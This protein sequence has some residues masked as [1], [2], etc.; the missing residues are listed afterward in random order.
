MKV[1]ENALYILTAL[2]YRKVGNAAITQ[3]V[4]NPG[5]VDELLAL[6]KTC[7]NPITRKDFERQRASIEEALEELT[8]YADGVVAFGDEEFPQYRGSVPPRAR[9]VALC[10]RGDLGLL[11]SANRN[12]A[13]IGL[14]NPDEY[15]MRFEREVV[16]ALVAEGATIVSGLAAGCDTVAHDETL[17]CGGKTV[18]I[19][20]SPLNNVLP[21]GNWELAEEI[22]DKGGL[23]ISE[24]YRQHQSWPELRRR[25][26]E[27]DRLQALFSDCVV[28]TAS[29]APN[30]DGNDSGSRYAMEAAKK[31]S[32]PRAVMY[33]PE[34]D[35]GNPKY[36]LNRQIMAEDSSVLVISKENLQ[37]AV[38]RIVSVQPTSKRPPQQPGLFS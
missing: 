33:N 27:R 4:K 23:L 38:K 34:T 30:K 28:L 11:D 31:Y 17:R 14:L 10:Y 20:P 2:C 3:N 21:K 16:R 29:Y 8:G 19:L 22:V 6:I 32:L 1:S 12:V 9:P 18:A 36:D 15:T 26:P 24:Y 35:D 13:V 37:E 25:Y 5:S 7:G